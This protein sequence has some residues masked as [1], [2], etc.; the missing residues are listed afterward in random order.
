MH[1]R[2]FLHASAAGTAAL[3]TTGCGANSTAIDAAASQVADADPGA[4]F[5]TEPNI[6]GPFY[7][8]GAPSRMTL[9]TADMPGVRLHLSGRVLG[10]AACTPLT[11]A[12]LDIWQ[13]DAEGDYYDDDTLRGVLQTDADGT[14]ELFTLIPG[15]YLNGNVYRPAHIHVKASAAGHRLIT[16]QL[17]FEGDEHNDID[18]FIRDSLIMPLSDGPD[19]SKRATFDFVLAPT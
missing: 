1:R 10:G 19:G 5:V 16:T 14:Y 13:A 3:F 18:P 8:P 7:I 4:C 17:Y 9:V 2:H 15:H 11:G 12:T 6:E